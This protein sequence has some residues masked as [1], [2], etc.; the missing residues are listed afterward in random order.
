MQL[1][2]V[3]RLYQHIKKFVNLRVHI[4]VARDS[5][6]QNIQYCSKSGTFEEHGQKTNLTEKPI[7]EIATK[8]PAAFVKFGRGLRNVANTL[9]IG[10]KYDHRT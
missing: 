7:V 1:Q 3:E 6:E 10:P 8:H 9:R 2:K 5:E 4:E